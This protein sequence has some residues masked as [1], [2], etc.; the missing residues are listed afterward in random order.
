MNYWGG[1][2]AGGTKFNCAIADDDAQIL[3]ETSFPTTSPKET[4]EK[5]TVFLLEQHQR[6]PLSAVGIGSFGP[7]DLDPSSATYG[8]ITTTPKPGWEN[9]DFY[10]KIKNSLRIPVG[11]DTDVNAAALGEFNLGAGKGL[12]S[13]VYLTIGTGIGGGVVIRGEPIHGLIHPEM[14]HIL[15]R[16]DPDKDP[17]PGVCPYHGDCLEGLA[18]GPALLARW[19]QPGDSLPREHLGWELEADYIAQGLSAI[20]M[21]LSPQRIILGG[22]VMHQLHL[23]PRIHRNLK[24][25]LNGYLSTPVILDNIDKYVVP[26]RLGDRAG[27]IGAIVLAQK[28]R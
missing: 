4:I 22:G 7:V 16:R 20:T 3:V 6:T 14:G 1:I 18:S 24:H 15:L 8:H 2:E 12:D 23:F 17:F 9:T 25:Y 27:I 11:F 19:G 21:I 13:I 5:A 10:S 28:T 26:P